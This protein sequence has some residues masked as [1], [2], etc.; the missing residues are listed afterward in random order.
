MAGGKTIKG[1]MQD[2]L[3]TIGEEITT[4]YNICEAYTNE[5]LISK[6][7]KAQSWEGKLVECAKCF[8]RRRDDLNMALS[9]HAA[10]TGDENAERLKALQERYCLLLWLTRGLIAELNNSV[11]AI[12]KV[13]LEQVPADGEREIAQRIDQL[14]RQQLLKND[15]DLRNLYRLE[16]KFT[17]SSSQSTSAKEPDWGPMSRPKSTTQK[18]QDDESKQLKTLR[19]NI[20]SDV[21]KVIQENYRLFA[22]K[23]KIELDRVEADLKNSMERT[24][25]RVIEI[26]S[27]GPWEAIFN[28]VSNPDEHSNIQ[29][30]VLTGS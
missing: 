6:A 22:G 28:E 29:Y 23:L 24:G 16:D 7:W 1:R 13:I 15:A 21:D 2:L 5:R 27:G 3:E 25:D 14:G 10:R 8:V 17:M 26:L 30:G 19:D 18:D 12:Y 20:A 9:A 4:T 11:D